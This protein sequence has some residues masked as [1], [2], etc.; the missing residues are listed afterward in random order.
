M[1][2]FALRELH[3]QAGRLLHIWSTH[4]RIEFYIKLPQRYVQVASEHTE[5]VDEG[6]RENSQVN[7]PGVWNGRCYQ[8]IS[9]NTV[10]PKGNRSFVSH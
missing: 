9:S 1:T 7:V 10:F 4:E 8:E 2:S 5:H 3:H 6:K